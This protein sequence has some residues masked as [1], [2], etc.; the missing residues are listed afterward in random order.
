MSE[1][2]WVTLPLEKWSRSELR[3]E[4]ERLRQERQAVLDCVNLY[5]DEV[6]HSALDGIGWPDVALSEKR[7]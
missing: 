6:L 4:V 1:Q 5:G 2:E 7:A 3:A